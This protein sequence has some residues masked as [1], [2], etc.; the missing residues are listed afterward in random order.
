[1]SNNESLLQCLEHFCS[2]E[3]LTGDN[4]YYCEKC[5]SRNNSTKILTFQK[6]PR[7]LV[8]HLKRFD[9]R[10][11]KIKKF[12]RY[13]KSLPMG[14]Y[15]NSRKKEKI[16]Y[17]LSSV[18]IHEGSSIYSGHYFCYLRVDDDN[19]Y[20]F[21]DQRV[22][23]VEESLVMKQTPYI[24]FYEKVIEKTRL[25]TTSK[26]TNNTITSSVRPGR[27]KVDH[28]KETRSQSKTKKLNNPICQLDSISSRSTRKKVSDNNSVSLD[29]RRGLRQTV[30]K[31]KAAIK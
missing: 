31:K 13:E 4:K 16:E 26:N 21:N 25:K 7:I 23:P 30:D 19:W 20:C 8:V 24:L 12:V 28:E 14:K 29:T 2:P 9:N 10:Q 5:R 15:T 11:R 18:L 22:F 1:M 6:F 17:R 3:Q 27:V